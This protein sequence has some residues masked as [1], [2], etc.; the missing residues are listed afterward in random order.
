MCALCRIRMFADSSFNGDISI[1]N[2]SNV[3]NNECMFDNCPIE[4][5]KD[6]H[7]KITITI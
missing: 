6:K 5:Q 3:Y 1:W 4:T 7:P 2:V